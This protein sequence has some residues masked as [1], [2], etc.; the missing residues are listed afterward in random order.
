M[1]RFRILAAAALVAL[2]TGFVLPLQSQSN[3]TDAVPGKVYV[4][5]AM[6]KLYSAPS[7]FSLVQGFASFG[8]DFDV[9]GKEN[10]WY[11]VEVMPGEAES[12]AYIH[13]QSI[14]GY[15]DMA[16]ILGEDPEEFADRIEQEALEELGINNFSERSSTSYATRGFSERAGVSYATRGFSQR[17]SVSF[18]TRGFSERSSVSF[19][20]RGF[21]ERSAVSYAT[22]GFSER[23]GVSYATR[24]F[25]ERSATSY[26]TRGFSERDEDEE[27]ESDEGDIDFTLIDLIDDSDY[28][29]FTN[30]NESLREF[31]QEGALGEY[32]P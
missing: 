18:A 27:S 29:S 30:P 1:H 17:S 26:A 8:V 19:A 5:M 25:S 7:S 12:A 13:E 3:D 16:F 6:A 14:L 32:R 24:G 28:L 22:R 11:Y 21:S 31:R 9:R 2:L 15:D 10:G 23:T 4:S 20:T